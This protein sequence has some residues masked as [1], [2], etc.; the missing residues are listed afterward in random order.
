[1]FL[2]VRGAAGLL[3]ESAS[4]LLKRVNV[5]L[6]TEQKMARLK[7]VQP[8]DYYM[9]AIRRAKHQRGGI[10][11][12]RVAAEAEMKVSIQ[13]IENIVTVSATLEA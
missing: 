4:G 8:M 5:V 7:E 11:L 13:L 2:S 10:G 3:Q 12:G 9:E 6:T 1:M